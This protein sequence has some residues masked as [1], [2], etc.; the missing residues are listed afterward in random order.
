[1]FIG[2]TSKLISNTRKILPNLWGWGLGSSGQL[3]Q[4]DTSS[5]TSPRKTGS[6]SN[7]KSISCALTQAMGIKSSIPILRSIDQY[8]GIEFSYSFW[9][10]VN[11]LEYKDDL[12]F[13]HV[14]NKGS[15]PN[16]T[17]EGGSG[18]F[19]PNNCPGV[20]LYKG[21]RNY[22]DNL[23]DSYPLLG[24]LVRINVYHNN[25][26]VAKAYYDDIYIDA[27]PIKK[28]VGVVIRATSQNIVDIYING[29]LTKRHKLSNIVKQNYDNFVI[30]KND[31]G[32]LLTNVNNGRVTSSTTNGNILTLG[33]FTNYFKQKNT[34]SDPT[35]GIETL[36]DSLYINIDDT[37][38]K[39]KKG[40]TFRLVFN[41]PIA[42]DGYNLVFRTDAANILGGGAYGKIIY[43][44]LT[45][46][47]LSSKPIIEITCTDDGGFNFELDILR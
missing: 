33:T 1:M 4:G 36:Q 22:S 18:L 17:G 3:G 35:T 16:S 30:C 21:K 43:T 40:Q 26:S 13:M 38:V 2:I 14:F 23:L 41:D 31:S 5:P 6:N 12:D 8:E 44:V 10:Y 34:N 11:N 29:N 42:T 9:M 47:L 46:E 28:W 15:P 24:M 7:W 45:S 39:W 32:Q 20:Y 37:N 27:I 19:G 25:N